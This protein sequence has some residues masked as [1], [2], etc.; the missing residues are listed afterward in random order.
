MKVEQELKEV[1]KFYRKNIEL[2]EKIE[3]IEGEIKQ[4]HRS[5]IKFFFP[6][7]LSVY[8]KWR[9]RLEEKIIYISLEHNHC[10]E[11]TV[12][13]VDGHT[14][15]TREGEKDVYHRFDLNPVLEEYEVANFIIPKRSYDEIKHLFQLEFWG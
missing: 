1:L 7:L 6:Y 8:E 2:E 5:I 14:V 13:S 4:N 3:S 10:Y 9:P 12:K 11:L 15:R